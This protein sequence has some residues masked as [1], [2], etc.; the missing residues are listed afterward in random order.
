MPGV[1]ISNKMLDIPAAVVGEIILKTLFTYPE[2]F[3]GNK[4]LGNVLAIVRNDT[5][6]LSLVSNATGL[7]WTEVAGTIDLYLTVETYLS[8]WNEAAA[9]ASNTNVAFK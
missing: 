5:T 7:T 8:N 9:T 4:T 3:T 2:L 6:I 1:A